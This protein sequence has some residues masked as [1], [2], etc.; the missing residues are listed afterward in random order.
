MV[1]TISPI[2]IATERKLSFRGYRITPSQLNAYLDAKTRKFQK[3]IV[4]YK[5][6]GGPILTDQDF[7]HISGDLTSWSAR[8]L[9]RAAR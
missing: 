9:A 2:K 8:W 6:R 7:D 3:L 1:A 4:Q 5:Q